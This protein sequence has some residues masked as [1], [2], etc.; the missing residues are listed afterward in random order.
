MGV[1]YVIADHVINHIMLYIA[2]RTSLHNFTHSKEVTAR[3]RDLLL[4]VKV[5]VG[6]L[7]CSITAL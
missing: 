1:S 7:V 2:A 3:E 6:V 4:S 5:S